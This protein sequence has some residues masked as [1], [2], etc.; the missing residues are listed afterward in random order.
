MLKMTKRFFLGKLFQLYGTC[1]TWGTRFSQGTA[2]IHSLFLS[3]TYIV[4]INITKE[5]YIALTQ[6]EL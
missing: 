6:R 5:I 1:T 3:H 4:Y 2:Y